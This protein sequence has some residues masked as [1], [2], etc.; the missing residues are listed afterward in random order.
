[1]EK[2]LKGPSDG[3]NLSSWAAELLQPDYGDEEMRKAQL[4]VDDM[5][6]RTGY[7]EDVQK[8]MHEDTLKI[9]RMMSEM[10]RDL[11]AEKEAIVTV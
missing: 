5:F 7:F 2:N 8:S 11:E 9:E 6:Q 10:R 3:Q 4:E 1:M